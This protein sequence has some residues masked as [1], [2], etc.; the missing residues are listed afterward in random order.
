MDAEQVVDRIIE[1]LDE[2]VS[3]SS[4]TSVRI[5]S[6][7]KQAQDLAREHLG[8]TDPMSDLV[9]QG[10]RD[11]LNALVF[12]AGLEAYFARYPQSRPTLGEVALAMAQQDGDP[13]ATRLDLA[14][15]QQAAEQVVQHRPDAS[16]EDVILWLHAQEAPRSGTRAA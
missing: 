13:L 4:V 1:L 3:G 8:L 14:A 12:H 10:I 6:N 9:E 2:P 16:P 7:V 11:K 5:H 15:F